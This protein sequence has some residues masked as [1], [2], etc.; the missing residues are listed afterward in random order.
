MP[1][2]SASTRSW[3]LVYS[4]LAAPTAAGTNQQRWA[5]SLTLTLLNTPE[6]ASAVRAIQ[7][8]VGLEAELLAAD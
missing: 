4:G 3:A 5:L 8:S 7:T 2:P 6:R 1:I